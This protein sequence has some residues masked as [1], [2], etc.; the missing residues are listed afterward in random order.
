M[1]P[2][3]VRSS[4]M[5]VFTQT[6]GTKSLCSN[7]ALYLSKPE[8]CIFQINSFEFDGNVPK[9][10]GRGMAYWDRTDTGVIMRLRTLNIAFACLFHGRRPC[11][12]KREAAGCPRR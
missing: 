8:T 2:Q 9:A 7:A 12:L 6:P 11:S 1:E 4:V 10:G 5:T 3:D